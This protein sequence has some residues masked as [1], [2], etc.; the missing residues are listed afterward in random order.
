MLFCAVCCW[1]A[2]VDGSIV[3]FDIF[4]FT[5]SYH[6]HKHIVYDIIV[7]NVSQA[8]TIGKVFETFIFVLICML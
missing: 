6:I 3:L 5:L 1:C 7:F 2:D 8:L 4:L